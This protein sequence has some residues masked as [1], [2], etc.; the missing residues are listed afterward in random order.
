MVGAD[1]N[2]FLRECVSD[3]ALGVVVAIAVIV[4]VVMTWL[5]IKD[6]LKQRR[7]HQRQQR[8][9]GEI[10]ASQPQPTHEPQEQK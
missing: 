3:P 8:R 5:I 10:K 7:A 6:K 2:R 4:A 9:R 1:M